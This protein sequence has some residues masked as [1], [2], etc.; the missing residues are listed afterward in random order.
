[1]GENNDSKLDDP[2]D[3]IGKRVGQEKMFRA[4][5]GMGYYAKSRLI[6][7]SESPLKEK[8]LAD[9]DNFRVILDQISGYI[10]S[11]GIEL[12]LKLGM[13]FNKAAKEPTNLIFIKIAIQNMDQFVKYVR[14]FKM[15]K[16]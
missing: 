8:F 2:Q 15:S 11:V 5:R 1:M 7:V 4:L 3:K 13:S 12:G 6:Q 16:L 14:M 10:P 9:F